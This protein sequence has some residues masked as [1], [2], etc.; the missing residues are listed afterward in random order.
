M[1]EATKYII[2]KRCLQCYHINDGSLTKCAQCNFLLL[3]EATEKEK[4]AAND[5]LERMRHKAGDNPN[6]KTELVTQE[7]ED[8]EE[9]YDEDEEND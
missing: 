2:M 3:A 9:E 8:Y 6:E 4:L 5:K 1:G 7:E